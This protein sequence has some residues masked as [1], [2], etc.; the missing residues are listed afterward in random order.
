MTNNGRRKTFNLAAP[1][2]GSARVNRG[3]WV[4]NPNC[5]SASARSSQSTGLASLASESRDSDGPDSDSSRCLAR[6]LASQVMSTHSVPE[7]SER[8]EAGGPGEA[9]DT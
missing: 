2:I 3:G 6:A 8:P 9:M 1:Y 7:D 5:T 4:K